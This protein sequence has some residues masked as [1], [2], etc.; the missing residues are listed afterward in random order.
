M[1]CACR[2]SPAPSAMPCA[3]RQASTALSA[4]PDLPAPVDCQLSR[5]VA[6][7]AVD[8]VCTDNDPRTRKHRVSATKAYIGD[9]RRR[10]GLKGVQLHGGMGMTD[11]VPVG[12]S[13]KRLSAIDM[14]Y[15]DSVRARLTFAGWSFGLLEFLLAKQYLS[16]TLPAK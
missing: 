14:L 7:D 5:S 13:L 1:S 12:H 10:M 9:I 16:L 8:A 2:R 4:A 6:W 11:D 15:G 3:C